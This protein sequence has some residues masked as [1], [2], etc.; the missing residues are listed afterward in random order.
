MLEQ[1]WAI[2]GVPLALFGLFFGII[3]SIRLERKF[4]NYEPVIKRAMSIVGSIGKKTQVD[5]QTVT[6]VEGALH[7]GVFQMLETKYP[8]LAL[9]MGYLEENHP[10]ILE[11]LKENP[12]I[13]LGLY[14]KYMPLITQLIGKKGGKPKMMYDA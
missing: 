3:Q 6:E 2:I 7:E 5:A 13:I 11:K 14:Q 1:I 12:S 4:R 9:V 8:E 10:E